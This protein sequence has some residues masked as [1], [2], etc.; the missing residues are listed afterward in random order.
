MDYKQRNNNN[1]DDYHEQSGN[2]HKNVN[3]NTKEMATCFLTIL[4][5]Y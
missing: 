2:S 4:D 1:M 5:I 3:E